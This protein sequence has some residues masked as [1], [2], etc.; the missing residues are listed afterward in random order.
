PLR[1]FK[2]SGWVVLCRKKTWKLNLRTTKASKLITQVLR[3]NINNDTAWVLAASITGEH[4]KKVECLHRALQIN[5]DNKVAQQ[6]LREAEGAPPPP[7]EPVE[8]TTLPSSDS[9]KL[10]PKIPLKSKPHELQKN[11][12]NTLIFWSRYI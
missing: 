6:S 10:S 1:A 2:V 11:D 7:P 3:Q 12:Q 4:D 9:V 8:T 5:P